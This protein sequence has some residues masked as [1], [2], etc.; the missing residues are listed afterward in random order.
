MALDQGPLRRSFS[1]A[2]F[3]VWYQIQGTEQFPVDN[4]TPPAALWNVFL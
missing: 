2:I 3:R 1:I 4:R